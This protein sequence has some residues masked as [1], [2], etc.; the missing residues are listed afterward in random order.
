MFG[1]MYGLFNAGKYRFYPSEDSPV[2]PT[3]IITLE[4]RDGP[5][6]A[7]E[8]AAYFMGKGEPAWVGIQPLKWGD[9]AANTVAYGPKPPLWNCVMG[10]RY[11]D[12]SP[13][14]VEEPKGGW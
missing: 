14:K 4:Y 9:W 3:T 11:I 1:I 12:L 13:P 2:D 6:I 5:P 7:A 10:K 8:N